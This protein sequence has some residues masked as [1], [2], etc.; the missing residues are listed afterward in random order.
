[1]AISDLP[2]AP[3]RSDTPADFIAKADAFVAALSTFV[4]EAN[5]QAAALT[6][7]STND[8][9]ASSVA[10]G[11]GAKS[12]T[13][14]TGKSFQPGMFI[15]IADTAAPSTNSMIAQITSY[16]SG[17]GALVV[18]VKAVL[19]SGTK[20]A[21]TISQTTNPVPL[22]LSVTAASLA[23]AVVHDLTAVTAVA[24]DYVFIADT[25]DSNKKKKALLQERGSATVT[26]V[27]SGGGTPTYSTQTLWWVRQGNKVDITINLQLATLGT[28]AAGTLTIQGNPFTAENVANKK[29]VFAVVPGNLAAAAT[30]SIVAD[31]AENTSS[32]RLF[33]YA[34]GALT[35]LAVSDLSG[36]AFFR[37]SGFIEV[38]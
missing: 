36:T 16:N 35:T 4:D 25:S 5:A 33:K 10:I 8:T 29:P 38:A 21:W 24:L 32:I 28:L 27:S 17:T 7:N 6:L 34:A 15:V 11:T 13:V 22:N 18:D 30:T 3:S 31:M 20:T 19:G 1:M 23:E 2:E 26:L 37:V 12:F 14:S 9:S